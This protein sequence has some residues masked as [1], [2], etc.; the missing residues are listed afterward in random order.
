[1]VRV[2]RPHVRCAVWVLVCS[3]LVSASAGAGDFPFER[4]LILD[5]APLPGSKRVPILEIDANG[6]VSIDLWCTSLRGQANVSD[7][8][9]SIVLGPVQPA[10]CAPDRQ[11]GDENLLAALVQVTNWRRNGDVTELRGATMLHFRLLTN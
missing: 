3:C 6:A 9:I 5:A 7:D 4:E 10:Q 2:R 8:T 11:A 1:M